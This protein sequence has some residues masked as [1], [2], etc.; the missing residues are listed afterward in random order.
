MND[1]QPSTDDRL[2]RGEKR[3]ARWL[4]AA[5][6]A[7]TVAAFA[8]LRNSDFVNFDD[9]HYVY[10]N[11]LVRGGFSWSFL[12]WALTTVDVY[13]WHPLTWLSLG[14][15]HELYGLDPRGYHATNLALHIANSVFLLWLL[16][17]MTGNVARSACAAAFFA[18]H[19]LHVESVVWISERKDVLSTFFWLA[20][21]AVYYR[22]CRRPGWLLYGAVLATF[23]LGLMAKPMLVTLPFVLLLMDYWPISRTEFIPFRSPAKATWIWLVAEKIPL[24]VLS[25][26]SSAITFL[27]QKWGGA[28]RAGEEYPLTGRL[29]NVPLNYVAYLRR[30][31][32]PADLAVLYPYPHDL[33]PL[34][35]PI[36]ASVLLLAITLAVFWFVKRLPYLFV[37]WFWFL[38]TL[39]PVMGI[40]QVGQQA[41]ADRY[42]YVPMIGLL[43]ALCWGIGDMAIRLRW[44]K[45]LVTVAAGFLL[46]GCAVATWV[47]VGY[48][49]DGPTL[50]R[51]ASRVAPRSPMV[52]NNLAVSLAD[53]GLNDQ[54]EQYLRTCLRIDPNWRQAHLNLGMILIQSGRKEEAIK[55]LKAAM[56][57]QPDMQ[58][59]G[60]LAEVQGDTQRAIDCYRKDVANDPASA[61]AHQLLGAA[62]IKRGNI[63]EGQRHVDEAQR[64]DP[65]VSETLQGGSFIH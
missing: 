33:P 59:L 65:H 26:A 9:D 40:V 23:L 47:Q 17:R 56:G 8:A 24:F 58:N 10:R 51:R 53:R 43:I 5:I 39:F 55:E 28:I 45:P 21:M 36:A 6:V 38:G 12:R 31:F 54:A 34:W 4:A 7:V 61:S 57:D 41:T 48:W 32:W 20:T 60:L 3:A 18:M 19:P 63:E 2:T 27:A 13:N 52:L 50:W 15:D 30:M 1:A 46:A 22:Y 49:R 35:Q 62:L 42:M 11:R 29:V 25:A 16:A 44:P 14:L 37:G 64:L